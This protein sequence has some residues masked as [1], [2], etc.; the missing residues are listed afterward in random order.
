MTF[1]RNIY[2]YFG[3]ILFL[4]ILSQPLSADDITVT[5]SQI[6]NRK[7]S[8]GIFVVK[9]FVSEIYKCPKCPEGAFCE[10]CM[11]PNIIL[12]EMYPETDLY[13][14]KAAN[15]RLLVY[16]DKAETFIISSKVTLKIKLDLQDSVDV[17]VPA[18]VKL[19]SV[20]P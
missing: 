14:K 3:L 5:I 20:E 9:G 2:R 11:A 1:L 19:I 10:P 15:K 6:N 4:I 8:K 17:T 13:T 7:V 12:S 18:S 16:T